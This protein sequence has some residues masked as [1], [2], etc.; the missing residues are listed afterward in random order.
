M[1]ADLVMGSMISKK[2]A[3]DGQSVPQLCNNTTHA[4][5]IFSHMAVSTTIRSGALDACSGAGLP[6]PASSGD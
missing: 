6:A 1:N 4:T 3:V 5:K 2:F